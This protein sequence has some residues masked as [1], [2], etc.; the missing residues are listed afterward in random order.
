MLLKLQV[1][2]LTESSKIILRRLVLNSV[3]FFERPKLLKKKHPELYDVLTKIFKQE[4]ADTLNPSI[5][6]KRGSIGRNQPCPYGSGLKYKRCCG[7]S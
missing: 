2:G 7:L 1:R 5:A 4:L 6:L 3:N